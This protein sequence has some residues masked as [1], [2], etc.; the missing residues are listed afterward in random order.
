V[1][2]LR[3][4]LLASWPVKFI[5]HFSK[6]LVFPRGTSRGATDKGAGGGA[7]TMGPGVFEKGYW[8]NVD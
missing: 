5:Y 4:T 8:K 2:G 1:Y 6:A 7:G 3:E